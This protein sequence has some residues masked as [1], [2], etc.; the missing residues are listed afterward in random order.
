MVWTNYLEKYESCGVIRQSLMFYLQIFVTIC[1]HE[2]AT[3]AT[4]I[5]LNGNRE[6]DRSANTW[7]SVVSFHRPF[8]EYGANV[9][10]GPSFSQIYDPPLNKSLIIIYFCVYVLYIIHYIFIFADS[11]DRSIVVSI[12]ETKCQLKMISSARGTKH[13]PAKHCYP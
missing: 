3:R 9:M 7:T 8:C 2:T 4:K 5:F 13:L 1:L 11:N 12:D 6:T 10:F